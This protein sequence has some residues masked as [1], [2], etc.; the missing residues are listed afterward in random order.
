[1]KNGSMIKIKASLYWS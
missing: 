1:M